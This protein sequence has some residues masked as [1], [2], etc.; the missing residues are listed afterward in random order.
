MSYIFLRTNLN[1]ND[2]SKIE[3]MLEL[4]QEGVA[5]CCQC[6]FVTQGEGEE[7]VLAFDGREGALSWCC[8]GHCQ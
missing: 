8:A 5:Y 4:A 6:A 3:V 7:M 2:T 1:P